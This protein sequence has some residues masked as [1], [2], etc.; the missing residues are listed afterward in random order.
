LSNKKNILIEDLA[1]ASI[2]LLDDGHCFRDQALSVCER[3]GAQE[4]SYRAT[5]L[6]TLVQM[7]AAGNGVTLLPLLSVPM[8]NRHGR[9]RL[10]RF[11]PDAP[12]RTLVL[13]WRK[14][15]ALDGVIARVSE[16]IAEGHQAAQVAAAL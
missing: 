14:G 4:L 1:G 11:S 7:T 13:V 16:V 5:S 15:S 8:E 6:G 12:F 3:S 2:L 10:R 9:L